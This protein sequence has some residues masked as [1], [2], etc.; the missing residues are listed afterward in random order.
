MP[1]PPCVAVAFQ[2][3]P[4]AFAVPK[5]MTFGSGLAIPLGDEHVRWLQV[6]MD[7]T[8]LVRVLDGRAHL[9]EQRQ[10][11]ARREALAIAVIGDG[12]RRR[13]TP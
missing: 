1:W 4:T 9:H 5:S 12:R 2:A 7:D 6:A 13:R 10:P 3:P 8:L 11:I